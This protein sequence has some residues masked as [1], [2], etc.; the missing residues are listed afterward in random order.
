MQVP[1]F[2]RAIVSSR[3]IVMVCLAALYAMSVLSGCGG[4]GG[5]NPAVTITPRPTTMSAGGPTVTFTAAVQHNQKSGLGVNWT[6]NGAGSFSNVNDVSVDYTP[7]S[8]PPANPTVTITATSQL[9]ASASD[10]VSFT[11]PS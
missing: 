1:T 8:T 2:I 9:D 10:S 5:N 7:P 11:I 3:K 4:G 6:L